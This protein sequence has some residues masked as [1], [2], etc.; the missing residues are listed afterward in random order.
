MVR[1]LDKKIENSLSLDIHGPH[2]AASDINMNRKTGYY[3]FLQF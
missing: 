2:S 3:N 1:S